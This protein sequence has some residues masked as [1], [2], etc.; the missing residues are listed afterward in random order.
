VV[1]FGNWNTKIQ[2]NIHWNLDCLLLIL[3]IRCGY[4]F[5]LILKKSKFWNNH[6][7]IKVQM[8]FLN[9]YIH[10][11][12]LFVY[13]VPMVHETYQSGFLAMCCCTSIA[14]CFGTSIKNFVVTNNDHP[15][16]FYPSCSHGIKH[17]IINY[18][19]YIT[20]VKNH[21]QNQRFLFFWML[22]Q[23]S[24]YFWKFILSI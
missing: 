24:F 13:F 19:H 21:V 4:N 2:F 23:H 16:S 3:L 20:D 10:E 18:E 14:A 11:G 22:L 9:I 5:I 1:G 6:E 17:H 7:Q 15:P 12:R 8:N